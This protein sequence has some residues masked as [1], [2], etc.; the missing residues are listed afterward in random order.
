MLNRRD[1]YVHMLLFKHN[2]RKRQLMSLTIPESF[3]EAK[4]DHVRRVAIL[5]RCTMKGKEE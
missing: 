2:S 3:F 5:L 1:W 4:V